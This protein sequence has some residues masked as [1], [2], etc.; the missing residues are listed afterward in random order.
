MLSI[1]DLALSVPVGTSSEH[2]VCPECGGG[3][4]KERSLVI[5]REP[6]MV[7]YACYRVSCGSRGRYGSVGHATDAQPKKNELRPYTGATRPLSDVERDYV[8]SKWGLVDDDVLKQDIKADNRTGRLVFPTYTKEGW[9]WGH[10]LR[11]IDGREPKASLYWHSEYPS[12][13]HFPRSAKTSESILLVEDIP[14]AIRA[15]SFFPSCAM[16]GTNL[17]VLR[18]RQI[19]SSFRSV[20]LALDKD[21]TEKA[22]KYKVRYSLMFDKFEVV[23]LHKDIKNMSHNELTTLMGTIL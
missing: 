22:V 19:C 9:E 13:L 11:S 4:T 15:S 8:W 14:S 2:L 20:Y 17:A 10:Q 12:R 23:P 6:G 3:A 16:L 21:A 5:R 1:K 18:V 7:H